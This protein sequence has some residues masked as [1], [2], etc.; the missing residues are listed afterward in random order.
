[1]IFA[2]NLGLFFVSETVVANYSEGQEEKEF[3]GLH[4]SEL[5]KAPLWTFSKGS[6]L[7]SDMSAD[8]K[9]IVILVQDTGTNVFFFNRS[10]STPL[11]NYSIP[12]S[13]Y[14]VAL[15]SDGN[16]FVAGAGNTFYFFSRTHSEPLWSYTASGYISDIAISSNG[17]YFIVG[18]GEDELLLFNKSGTSPMWSFKAKAVVKCVSM[19][20]DGFYFAIGTEYQ[21]KNVYVFNRTSSTPMWNYS[22]GGVVYAIDISKDGNYIAAGTSQ[23]TCLIFSKN[24]STPIQIYTPGSERYYSVA[25]SYNGRYLIAGGYNF[26]YY[27]FDTTKSSYL[28]SQDHSWG[29]VT[30]KVDIS[31]DGKYIGVAASIN[32][33]FHERETNQVK[34]KCDTHGDFTSLKLSSDG[35]YISFS[36]IAGEFFFFSRLP[37]PENGKNE[38]QDQFPTNEEEMD[39][40]LQF[41]FDRQIRLYIIFSL[42]SLIGI[43]TGVGILMYFRIDRKYLNETR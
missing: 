43:M 1:M 41:L 10:L 16:Y 42:I 2:L 6:V 39:P 21:D 4:L 13:L 37:Y 15:S 20:S 22:T 12:S 9:Y 40:F 25:L 33:H 27:F 26:Y 35:A 17:S 8:G 3:T 31:D 32:F 30:R 23:S 18:N 38:S 7:S 11:W 24:S 29:S 19:S 36:N 14:G 5:E 28:W 34:W